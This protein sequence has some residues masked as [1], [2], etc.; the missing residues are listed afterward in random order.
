MAGTRKRTN[1]VSGYNYSEK[2]DYQE[3]NK[4]EKTMKTNVTTEEIKSGAEI[5]DE[6]VKDEKISTEEAKKLTPSEYF[7]KIKG[8]LNENNKEN[9]IEFLN[10]AITLMKKPLV[11]GQKQMAEDIYKITMVMTKELEAVNAGFTK[12]VNSED[13][14]YYVDK[15]SDKV[16]KVV[17]LEKYEREIPD[18]LIDKIIVAKEIF[19]SLIVVFTDY[20]GRSERKIEEIKREKDPILFGIFKIPDRYDRSILHTRFYYI[21]DWVDEFCDLT[22]DK[23]VTEYKKKTK[24]DIVHEIN[25]QMSLEDIKST[26]S[27]YQKRISSE[28]KNK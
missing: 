4:K 16:V 21:G 9:I 13:L 3:N 11:T 14:I 17:Y 6:L 25:D 24:S 12:Y 10:N 22:L 26:I 8:M 2:S 20:T 23:M 28:G 19:D 15:V 18:E 7:N 5:L 1:K 27:N